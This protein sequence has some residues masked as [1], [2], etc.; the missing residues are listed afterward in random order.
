MTQSIWKAKAPDLYFPE[1]R[2]EIEADVAIIG[3]GI[4][5]ITTAHLLSKTGKKVVVL[6]AY[7][8]GEG[9]TSDSTGNLYS[10]VDNR[11]HHIQSALD[12]NTARVVAESRTSAVNL[13]EYLTNQYKVACNFKRMP[14]YL[15]SETGDKDE[16]IEKE[17]KIAE[18]LGMKVMS[19]QEL[20]LPF[21]I[22]SAIKIDNQAQFNPSAYVKGLAERINRQDC[23][24]YENS[25]VTN[26]QKNSVFVLST[27]QGRVKAT[28][29]ILATHTPKGVLAVQTVLGPYREYA[30]AAKLKSGIYPEGIFWSTDSK[31]HHS[32]RSFKTQSESY[33]LV[34]GEHHKVG[35]AEDHEYFFR[36][37]E[38]DVRKLFDI[39]SIEYRWSAQHYK[40][41]DGIPY[42]GESSTKGMYIATG[43]ST[44]G[45]VYGTVAA[46]ILSDTIS[47]KGNP[48]AE[49]YDS[50]RFTPVAS[51]KKFV[52]ENMNV[53]GEYLKAF[54][55]KRDSDILSYIKPGEGKVIENKSEKWAVYREENGHI[56][57][58]SAVCTHMKCIVNWNNAEKTWDCP[59][60]GNRFKYTGEVIEGPSFLPLEKKNTRNL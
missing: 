47:G 40:P 19:T 35:Q 9:T 50:K 23:R 8:T 25:G 31:H 38:N 59:C 13:I 55:A 22:K 46:M 21:Q 6:E 4:T 16:T 5:G 54:T 49:T 45:L 34:I 44:D 28:K 57:I 10:M 43:F 53:L 56:H 7:K 30:I 18:K 48:W 24:I 39:D 20:P 52:K 29:V 12:D 11:L 32:I 51:A 41:A 37:L 27:P 14:W 15:Y 42:I 17:R 3:G 58:V 2:E 26:I 36:Q 33:L 60:H 1:L